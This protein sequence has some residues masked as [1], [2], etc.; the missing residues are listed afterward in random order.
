MEIPSNHSILLDSFFIKILN[1]EIPISTIEE[2]INIII[3]LSESA[4]FKK[5]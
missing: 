4:S 5:L 1:R 3:I 2:I